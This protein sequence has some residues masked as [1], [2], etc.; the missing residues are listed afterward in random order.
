MIVNNVPAQTYLNAV[1]LFLSQVNNVNGVPEPLLADY[2]VKFG[3]SRNDLDD[4]S[5]NYDKP[6]HS[7]S[8]VW[9]RPSCRLFLHVTESLAASDFRTDCSDVLKVLKADLCS[10]SVLRVSIYWNIIIIIK[11]T[12]FILINIIIIIIIIKNSITLKENMILYI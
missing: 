4:N 3:G 1:P 10:D 11:I 5:T 9:V 6:P 12:T 2:P 7:E 8:P